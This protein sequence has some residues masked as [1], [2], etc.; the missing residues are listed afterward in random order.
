VASGRGRRCP[1][2]GRRL[3]AAALVVRTSAVRVAARDADRVYPSLDEVPP[4][5]RRRLQKAIRG[6]HSDTFVIADERG[7]EQLFQIVSGLPA[8][9]QKRVLAVLRVSEAP[10]DHGLPRSARAGLALAALA[11]LLT[12]LWLVWRF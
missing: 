10:Q 9:L 2:C 1:S 3:Q 8:H 5:L 12:L 7:R 4:E 6:P 11:T